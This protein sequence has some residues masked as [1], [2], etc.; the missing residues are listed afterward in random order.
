[1]VLTDIL[2]ALYA[3]AG[4][5]A[6]KSVEIFVSAIYHLSDIQG[7]ALVLAVCVHLSKIRLKGEHFDNNL[8]YLIIWPSSSLVMNQ[9]AQQSQ[10]ACHSF[11]TLTTS[12]IFWPTRLTTSFEKKCDRFYQ[13]QRLLLPKQHFLVALYCCCIVSQYSIAFHFGLFLSIDRL[14]KLASTT[15]N[16]KAFS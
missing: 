15:F 2:I 5:V 10:G 6:E 16:R 12:F 8:L 14:H 9:A 13:K 7:L 3:C 4:K 1:M 11:C